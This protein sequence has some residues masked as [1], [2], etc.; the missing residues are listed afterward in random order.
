MSALWIIQGSEPLETT[1]GVEL[2]RLLGLGFECSY[3]HVDHC[4]KFPEEAPKVVLAVDEVSWATL[5]FNGGVQQRMTVD[6]FQHRV[7]FFDPWSADILVLCMWRVGL[8]YE[9]LERIR[10][11][12]AARLA[13]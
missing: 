4:T 12:V 13:A 1:R 11:E 8:T 7:V 9:V 10:L 5:I 6:G 3:L 2:G